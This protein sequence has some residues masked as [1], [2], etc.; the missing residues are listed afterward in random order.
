MRGKNRV[1]KPNK[2]DT[3]EEGSQRWWL[4]RSTK[5]QAKML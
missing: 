4:G 3:G 1:K 5:G 2:Q